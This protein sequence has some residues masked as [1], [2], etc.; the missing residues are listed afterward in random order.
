MNLLLGYQQ[1]QTFGDMIALSQ[2]GIIGEAAA[3]EEPEK[4]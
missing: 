1:I 3:E 2:N 4:E